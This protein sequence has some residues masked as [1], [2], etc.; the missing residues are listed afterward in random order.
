MRDLCTRCDVF[1]GYGALGVARIPEGKPARWLWSHCWV[2]HRSR[3]EID[4]AGPDPD[5]PL[6]SVSTMTVTEPTLPNP[7]IA[8][9]GLR[10]APTDKGWLHG[11]WVRRGSGVRPHE[12]TLPEH[13]GLT[14]DLWRCS[15][16]GRL[17]RVL[18]GCE[19]CTLDRPCFVGLGWTPATRWQRWR[20]RRR[21]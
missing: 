21:P 15:S 19:D 11:S 14:G 10:L 18:G 13:G 5:G 4:A 8:E 20:N 2:C 17:W 3:E 6:P 1:I 7:G 9:N 16:C 12:C